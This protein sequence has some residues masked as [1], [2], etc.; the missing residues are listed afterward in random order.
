MLSLTKPRLTEIWKGLIKNSENQDNITV[1]LTS[2]QHFL[3]RILTKKRIG[4]CHGCTKFEIAV[5]QRRP[6]TFDFT[7]IEEI[8]SKY[9]CRPN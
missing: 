6:E 4:V 1:T 5:D 3:A 7:E 9:R 8:T 2:V